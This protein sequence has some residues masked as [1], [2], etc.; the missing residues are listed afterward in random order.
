MRHIKP[1]LTL[2]ATS[3]VMPE[4]VTGST[5]LYGFLNPVSILILFLGYGIAVLLIREFI[6]RN[7]INFLGMF[8]IGVAYVG[9]NEGLIAKTLT[10]QT[11]VPFPVFD[12]YGYILGISVPWV[13]MMGVWHA[14]YSVVF[15]IVATH[16]LFPDASKEPWIGKKKAFLFCAVVFF[17]ALGAFFGSH[18]GVGTPEQLAIIVISMI[19]LFFAGWFFGRKRW[20]SQKV[21]GAVSM[22]PVWLGMSMFL[23][24]TVLLALIIVATKMPLIIFFAVFAAVIIFYARTLKNRIGITNDTLLLFILGGYLQTAV[25]GIVLTVFAPATAIE[26][27]PSEI[28][29]LFVSV[30]LIRKVLSENKKHFHLE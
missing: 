27:I 30:L 26:R 11:G 14:L 16:F 22:R 28:F 18:R 20:D 24:W 29:I 23:T 21:N 12:N 5:P 7:T 17:L 25:T 19:A 15:P 1:I 10:L 6:V 13:L 3:M 9:L 2:I 4:L 8:L